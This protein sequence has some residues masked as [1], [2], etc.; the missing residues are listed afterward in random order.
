[1]TPLPIPADD[2]LTRVDAVLVSHLHLDHFDDAAAKLLPKHLPVICQP[3]DRKRLQARGLTELH[4]VDRPIQGLEIIRTSGK[5]GTGLIGWAMGHVFGFILRAPGEPSLYI[6]GDTIWCA[7]VQDALQTHRP[8]VIVLNAGGAQFRLGAPI[9]MTGADIAQVCST[10]PEAQVI[11]VHMETVNH[12][13][14]TRA[15]LRTDLERRGALHRVHIPADGE[16]LTF[17]L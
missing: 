1:M 11:A 8:E 9:T 4:P 12:C 6:A 17:H 15:D 2:L 16:T 14:Q 5:H 13:L 10:A 7:D 3:R